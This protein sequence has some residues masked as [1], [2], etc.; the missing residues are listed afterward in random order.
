MTRKLTINEIRAIS[1][2]R[3]AA[4]AHIAWE[5]AIDMERA[6]DWTPGKHSARFAERRAFAAKEQ[7]R[8][9]CGGEP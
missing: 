6:F 5:L 7:L 4:D 9:R 3:L 8:L 1:F 2:Q